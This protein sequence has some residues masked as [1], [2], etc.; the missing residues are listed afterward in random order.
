MVNQPLLK[1][2]MGVA[3]KRSAIISSKTFRKWI[4]SNKSKL[5]PM[6]MG[7]LSF[8]MNSPIMMFQ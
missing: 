5:L 6:P 7:T 8:V 1:K 4:E 3:S 2:E